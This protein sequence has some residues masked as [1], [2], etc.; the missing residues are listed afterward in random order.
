MKNILLNVKTN[1]SDVVTLI[2]LVEREIRDIESN[3]ELF[4]SF[5]I[6]VSDNLD[7]MESDLVKFNRISALLRKSRCESR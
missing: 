5:D 7:I 6:D 2:V 1:D 4:K 3:I